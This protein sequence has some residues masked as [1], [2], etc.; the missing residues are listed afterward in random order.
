LALSKKIVELH[1]GSIS[2]QSEF[3]KG[4]TF[5]F[6][7]PRSVPAFGKPLMAM[8]DTLTSREL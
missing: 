3:G 2:V 7:M 6:T 5:S 8:G 4:S 1:H